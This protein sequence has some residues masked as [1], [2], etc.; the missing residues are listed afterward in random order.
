[1]CDPLRAT[2]STWH[3]Y[4]RGG[5]YVCGMKKLHLDSLAIAVSSLLEEGLRGKSIPQTCLFHHCQPVILAKGW[6]VLFK[7][8]LCIWMNKQPKSAFLRV[9]HK[10][11]STNTSSAFTLRPSVASHCTLDK[12]QIHC[13]SHGPASCPF[14]YLFTVVQPFSVPLMGHA[15]SHPHGLGTY[16]FLSPEM[17]L[18]PPKLANFHSSF[19]SQITCHF[20]RELFPGFPV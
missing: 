6:W 9:C 7:H 19:K 15:V 14:A 8:L 4:R 13:G 5:Q 2:T 11:G 3:R 1:M 20:L 17:P 12:P 10:S 16:C 18:L